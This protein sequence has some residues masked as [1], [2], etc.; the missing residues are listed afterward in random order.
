MTLTNSSPHSIDVDQYTYD[1]K[2][3]AA[4]FQF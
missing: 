3:D 2:E 4:P 1:T